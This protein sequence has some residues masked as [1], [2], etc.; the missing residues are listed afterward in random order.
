M[1]EQILT[2]EIVESKRPDLVERDPGFNIDKIVAGERPLFFTNNFVFS[3]DTPFGW[4]R[5]YP[6]SAEPDFV[7]K[8]DAATKEVGLDLSPYMEKSYLISDEGYERAFP[9]YLKLHDDYGIHY[10]LLWG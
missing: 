1:P 3:L 2:R 8:V 5:S 6:R 7:E 4:G 10:S 9:V